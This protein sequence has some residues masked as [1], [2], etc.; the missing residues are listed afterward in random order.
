MGSGSAPALHSQPCSTCHA[1]L[2]GHVAVGQ[3]G[4]LSSRSSPRGGRAEAALRVLGCSLQSAEALGQVGPEP[5]MPALSH[6]R[7]VAVRTVGSSG[8]STPNPDPVMPVSSESVMPVSSGNGSA[9][10]T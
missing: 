9:A 3:C 8:K 2:W 6:R 7:D 1:V 5:G 4:C 10:V